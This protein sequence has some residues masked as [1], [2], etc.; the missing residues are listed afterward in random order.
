MRCRKE[1]GVTGIPEQGIRLE[2]QWG[3]LS[4]NGFECQRI[5]QLL[6]KGLGSPWSSVNRE[7]DVVRSGPLEDSK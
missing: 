1:I 4:V 2:R 7:G 3:E 6:L 5:L